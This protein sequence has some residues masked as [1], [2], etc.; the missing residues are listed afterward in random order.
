[1]Y[2]GF[3]FEGEAYRHRELLELV[4]DLGGSIL[5]VRIIAQE[6]TITFIIPEEDTPT[7]RKLV[8]E[9]R[10][11]LRE[12]PLVGSEIAVVSPTIT[13]HHL[14]H[15]A[16]DIAE[17]LR[18]MGAKTNIIGLARGVGQRV[19]QITRREKTLI[20]EHDAAVFLLGNFDYCLLEHKWKLYKDLRIPV[21]VA[22]GPKLDHVPYA[23]AYISGIGRIP[24]RTRFLSEIRKLDELAKAVG[25]CLD[26]RRE[27]IAADP[28]ITSPFILKSE[29]EK[30]IEEVKTCYSPAPI[31]PQLD[32]VRV[33]LRYDKFASIIKKIRVGNYILEDVAEVRRSMMKNY[34][35]IKLYP[36]SYVRLKELEL[37]NSQWNHK[38]GIS[39]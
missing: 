15:P 16:C 20:E 23:S 30:Q 7:L 36:K 39:A 37:I 3:I 28:L 4:E 19:A 22:G 26:G 12:I 17:Y 18:R 31:V 32:G 34:I 5:N 21:I 27:M 10:A 29:I 35:L 11:R 9:L 13:R 1:M 6:A 38:G 25:K 8:L 14:P 33:K 2:N 24:Y